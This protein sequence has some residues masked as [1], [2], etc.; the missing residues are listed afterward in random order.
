MISIR[1]MTPEE[2]TGYR[3]Y[4]NEFRGGELS[5]AHQVTVD[6]GIKLAN[7]ELD[8][9]LPFGLETRENYLLCIEAIRARKTEVVGY[10]WYGYK[11]G[12]TSA[13]IY[14]I[15]I[16]P[17]Y[18]GKGYGKHVFGLLEQTPT[19]QGVKQLELLVASDNKRAYKLYTELGFRATGINMVKQTSNE[20]I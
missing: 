5:E 10:L 19:L 14:D 1:K 2:F 16:F 7:N 11:S 18:R 8:D 17:I 12:D 6:E 20:R 3:E 4:S 13:F 9:C 15:Q